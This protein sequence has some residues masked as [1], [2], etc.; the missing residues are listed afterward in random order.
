MRAQP[1][2]DP[3]RQEWGSC[4][5]EPQLLRFASKGLHNLLLPRTSL[6]LGRH[7][8]PAVGRLAGA[9]AELLLKVNSLPNQSHFSRS[10]ASQYLEFSDCLSES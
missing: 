8:S 2:G 1:P 5:E 9:A 10:S 7:P 6:S 3:A 4:Q